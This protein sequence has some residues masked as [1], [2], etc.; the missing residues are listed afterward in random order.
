MIGGVKRL[1]PVDFYRFYQQKV[2][3]KR[4]FKIVTPFS[5]LV[6]SYAYNKVE[7]GIIWSLKKGFYYVSDNFIEFETDD[8]DSAA[9]DD[10]EK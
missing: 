2:M 5:P 4:F 6:S 10:E 1:I 8:G 7:Q 9:A 3:S